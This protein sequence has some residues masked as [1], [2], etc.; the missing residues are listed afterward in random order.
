MKMSVKGNLICSYN[1]RTYDY[2]NQPK[3]LE[4]K[5]QIPVI[6]HSW[7]CIRLLIVIGSQLRLDTFKWTILVVRLTDV[8]LVSDHRAALDTTP[9][10]ILFNPRHWHFW[11][12]VFTS[13]LCANMLRKEN[14]QR[15]QWKSVRSPQV[16]AAHRNLTDWRRFGGPVRC[17]LRNV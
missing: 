17:F 4:I 14:R 11:F 9:N 12:G 16:S 15:T 2:V 10:P 6:P 1:C 3:V 13:L 8:A 7:I 5:W